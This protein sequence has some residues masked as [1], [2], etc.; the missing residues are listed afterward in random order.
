MRCN[1]LVE[2]TT[3]AS[4]VAPEN[5][6]GTLVDDRRVAVPRTGRTPRQAQ[7]GHPL[8]R[9][10][11]ELEEVV[12]ALAAVEP[13]QDVERI[14]VYDA[15][16]TIPRRRRRPRSPHVRPSPGWDTELEEVIHAVRAIVTCD[17][18]FKERKYEDFTDCTSKSRTTSMSLALRLFCAVSST[19]P[20]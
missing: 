9:A 20:I 17:R 1:S 4:V 7:Q 18:C 8:H 14:G 19:L 13:A 12:H 10:E 3:I 2:I 5:E 16:V 11:V 15:R 6:H